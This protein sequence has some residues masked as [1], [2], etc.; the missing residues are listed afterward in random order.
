MAVGTGSSSSP[1]LVKGAKG[2]QVL[3][4]LSINDIEKSYDVI[5]V[6]R[7]IIVI[8]LSCVQLPGGIPGASNLANSA[9]VETVL[10][11]Q[12]ADP[13]KWIAAI[14]AAPALVLPKQ[15][16]LSDPSVKAVCYPGMEKE[17]GQHFIN[18]DEPVHVDQAHHLSKH[19]S[20][21]GKKVLYISS[22][23]VQRPRHSH[24]IRAAYCSRTAGQG[25]S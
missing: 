16:L 4:E 17:L 2:V 18:T 15:G 21:T 22:S 14:C 6:R 20:Y 23:H 11:Q 13:N 7:P 25:E 9:Q 24:G 10:K 12:Q 1:L 8:P 3:A 19:K 5:I